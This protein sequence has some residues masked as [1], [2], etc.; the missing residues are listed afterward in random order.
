MSEGIKSFQMVEWRKKNAK[1]LV[2]THDKIRSVASCNR[3]RNKKKKKIHTKTS[4]RLLF[5]GIGIGISKHASQLSLTSCVFK[6]HQKVGHTQKVQ[7]RHRCIHVSIDSTQ[8]THCSATVEAIKNEM[9]QNDF[10]ATQK[11]MQRKTN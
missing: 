5:F 8:S 3:K 9:G 6:Y 7:C 4:F 2:T 1:C 10:R 11:L